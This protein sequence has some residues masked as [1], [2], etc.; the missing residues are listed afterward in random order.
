[1]GWLL[2]RIDDV[3]DGYAWVVARLV[4]AHGAP[5]DDWSG[6]SK[7]VRLDTSARGVLDNLELALEHSEASAILAA[8]D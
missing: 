2:R 4:R 8:I 7:S 1:M 5:P 6:S 3:R